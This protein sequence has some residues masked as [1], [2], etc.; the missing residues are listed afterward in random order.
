M[1]AFLTFHLGQSWSCI[2]SKNTPLETH[3]IRIGNYLFAAPNTVPQDVF[4]KATGNTTIEVRWTFTAST[5]KGFQ[6]FSVKYKADGDPT[7][8]ETTTGPAKKNITL[9][10]LRIFTNYNIRVAARTTQNGNYSEKVSAK[11]LEGGKNK[12]I[13]MIHNMPFPSFLVPL[14]ENESSCMKINL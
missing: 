4:A 13:Y 5:I 9:T 10:N 12:K 2:K 3:R 7:W 14:F 1:A 6:G 8:N 11:T